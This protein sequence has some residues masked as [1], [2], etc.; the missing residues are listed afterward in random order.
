V[1]GSVWTLPVEIACYVVAATLVFLFR[2]K[3][4]I[5]FLLFAL[6]LALLSSSLLER[7]LVV[8][9]YGSE[10]ASSA[11]IAAFF[12]AGGLIYFI[13]RRFQNFIRIDVALVVFVV[14]AFVAHA[15]LPGSKLIALISIPYLVIAFGE[16]N[17]P[18]LRRFG[19]FGDPSYGIYLWAFP[20][21]QA[22]LSSRVSDLPLGVNII[23]V[24]MLS[25]LA[26]YASW[27]F[28]EKRA[29]ALGQKL[30]KGTL[31]RSIVDERP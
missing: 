28:A 6:F 22:I 23:V 25:A 1:N 14:G 20:I 21:Q 3:A 18:I 24:L 30:A 12:F 11:G 15:S 16:L 7:G 27:H 31:A 10:L 13:Q 5:L 17:T 26:G 8:V 19:R 29:V 9:F 4:G 2:R